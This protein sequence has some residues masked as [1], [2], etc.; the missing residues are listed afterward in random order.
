MTT[1]KN[2]KDWRSNRSSVVW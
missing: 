2:F 1:F